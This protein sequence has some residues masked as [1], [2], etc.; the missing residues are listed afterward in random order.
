MEPLCVIVSHNVEQE[1]V[2]VIVESF[3]VKE[4]FS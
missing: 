4:Q 1:G 3:V 2:R